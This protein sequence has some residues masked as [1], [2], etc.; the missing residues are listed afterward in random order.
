MAKKDIEEIVCRPYCSFYREGVKEEL[1][2]NG[3]LLLEKLLKNIL[4]S[5]EELT[6]VADGSSLST[7]EYAQLE[8]IVCRSCPFVVDG[9]DF[10]SDPPPADA[11][12]CGGFILLA[13]LVGKD[14]VHMARLK[15]IEV[16]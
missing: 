5:P 4:L 2:C 1:I 16:E 12:P 14:V 3:A 6:D 15:E 13:L 8:E 11:E 7:M 10:S 9:C